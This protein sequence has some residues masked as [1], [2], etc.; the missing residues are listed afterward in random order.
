MLKEHKLVSDSKCGYASQSVSYPAFAHSGPT[1]SP[2]KEE[3]WVRDK[4]QLGH[5]PPTNKISLASPALYYRDKK[6]CP[7]LSILPQLFI[8][9]NAFTLMSALGGSLPQPILKMGKQRHKER[10]ILPKTTQLERREHW[11][12]N[13]GS[14][15]K[16]CT[17]NSYTTQTPG[18]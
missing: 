10:N 7:T 12:L 15:F 11:D 3:L 5:Q 14:C 13:P 16:V 4:M 9:S 1:F 17:F 18:P 6:V 8:S 2:T